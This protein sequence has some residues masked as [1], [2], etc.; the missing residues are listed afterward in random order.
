TTSQASAS[1]AQD[2]IA[3]AGAT[4]SDLFT[5][6]LSNTGSAE[7]NGHAPHLASVLSIFAIRLTSA[8]QHEVT[9]I[10]QIATTTMWME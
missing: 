10:H 4:T 5:R 2:P 6:L 1:P 8:V 3:G 9:A 7:L